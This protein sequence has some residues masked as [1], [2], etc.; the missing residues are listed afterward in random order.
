MPPLSTDADLTQFFGTFT[1][2]LDEKGRLFLP[3]KFRAQLA[4][5]VVLTRGQDHCI[6]GWTKAGFQEFTERAR[7]APF[8]NR[9]A[10]NF[11]RMLYSGASSEVPDKQGRISISTVLREWAHL[12]R[13]CTVVGAMERIEIWD[14]ARW[15]EFSSAQEES[16]ADMSEEI[17][18]GLF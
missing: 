7:Q 6:F 11:I 12:E 16:F 1:P 17:F 9:D 15:T 18:P 14:S 5:G 3:A 2:R 13:E 4:D 8:S 10:R